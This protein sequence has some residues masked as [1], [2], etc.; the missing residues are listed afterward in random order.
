MTAMSYKDSPVEDLHAFGSTAKSFT[1][2]YHSCQLLTQNNLNSVSVK[3]QF[4]TMC[5]VMK[6]QLYSSAACIVFIYLLNYP[7]N[8][9][10][11]TSVTYHNNILI[12]SYH[13]S[14]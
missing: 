1:L 8:Q 14:S 2:S 13:F 12:K 9:A 5:H 3:R 7:L 6:I 4:G 10:Q 11:H